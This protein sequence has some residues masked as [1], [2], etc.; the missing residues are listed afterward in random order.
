ML[1][2]LPVGRCD[3]AGEM[4]IENVTRYFAA[5]LMEIEHFRYA[6]RVVGLMEIEHLQQFS[7]T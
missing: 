5:G 3:S 7:D 4:K 2:S 6:P 1:H